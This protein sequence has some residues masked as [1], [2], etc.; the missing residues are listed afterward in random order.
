[1]KSLEGV[2]VLDFLWAGAGAWGS[3]FLASY[4]AEV[5]RIEWIGHPDSMR[6]GRPSLA[7]A[8]RQHAGDDGRPGG[9]R[10]ALPRTSTPASSA[11]A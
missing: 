11:S 6:Y 1:M 8:R 2:R 9:P 3:R 4:G 10:G 7:D 5:I